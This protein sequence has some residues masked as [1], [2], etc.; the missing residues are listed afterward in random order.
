MRLTSK[1]DTTF[2]LHDDALARQPEL[3]NCFPKNNLTL[4]ATINISQVKGIPAVP[5][6]GF[7]SQDRFLQG[8][9]A[10]HIPAFSEM[11]AP[12]NEP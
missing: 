7:Q 12:E 6:N 10:I 8:R 2:T 5:E 4:S 3:A 11:H 1:A 9:S